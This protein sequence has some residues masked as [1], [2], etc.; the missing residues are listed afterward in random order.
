M[1]PIKKCGC[2]ACK[3]GMHSGKYGS[4]TMKKVVRKYRH[5]VKEAIRKGEEVPK[6]ISCDYT[7]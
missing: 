3:E 7:D 5:I 6:T 1:N 4:F 2:R